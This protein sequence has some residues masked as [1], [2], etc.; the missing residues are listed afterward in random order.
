MR[1]LHRLL[2]L[3]LQVSGNFQLGHLRLGRRLQN[4]VDGQHLQHILQKRR[5]ATL[6]RRKGQRTLPLSDRSN[7]DG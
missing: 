3:G 5:P 4:L 2:H 6:R 7:E 1:S